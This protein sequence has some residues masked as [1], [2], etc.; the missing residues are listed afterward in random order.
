MN[1]AFFVPVSWAAHALCD[2]VGADA[3]AG[4]IA[5]RAIV[6]VIVLACAAALSIRPVSGAIDF[7]NRAAIA[8]GVMFM[9]S[10]TQ[11]PWYYLWLVPFLAVRPRV[12]LLIWSVTLPLYYLKFHYAARGEA[13][14][15]HTRIVWLEHAPVALA[16]AW[17]WFAWRRT[18]EASH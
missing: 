11:F 14:F 2:A 6:A 5:A 13:D 18:P 3:N 10:P 4:D 7:C 17:E 16:A 8:L 9:L 12:S 1:D 15:F